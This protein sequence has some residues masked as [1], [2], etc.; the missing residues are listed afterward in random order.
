MVMEFATLKLRQNKYRVFPK[1]ESLLQILA[2]Q[3]GNYANT[4]GDGMWYLWDGRNMRL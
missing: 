2:R 1:A 4:H 3:L